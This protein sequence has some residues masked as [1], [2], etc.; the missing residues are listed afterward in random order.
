MKALTSMIGSTANSCQG[1]LATILFKMN[2]NSIKGLIKPLLHEI[3]LPI[4]R[5][6]A[7]DLIKED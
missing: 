1:Y 2:V 3:T 5:Q 4:I 7:M 6:F